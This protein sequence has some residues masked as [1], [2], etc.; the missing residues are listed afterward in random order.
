MLQFAYFDGILNDKLRF[1][2]SKLLKLLR[3]VTL[4][5]LRLLAIGERFSKLE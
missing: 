3:H 2:Y 4:G 1:V 5:I